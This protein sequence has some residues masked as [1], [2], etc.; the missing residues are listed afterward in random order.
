[1]HK[2][3]FMWTHETLVTMSLPEDGP[4]EADHVADHNNM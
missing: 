4:C 3:Q 2:M 1:M